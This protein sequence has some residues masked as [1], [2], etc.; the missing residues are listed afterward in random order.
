MVEEKM[1]ENV[2]RR[3]GKKNNGKVNYREKRK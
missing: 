3:K 1:L 2:I